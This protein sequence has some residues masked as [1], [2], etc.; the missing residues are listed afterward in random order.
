MGHPISSLILPDKAQ[1]VRAPGEAPS[2]RASSQY[3]AD[4]LRIDK[5][6][7]MTVEAR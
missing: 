4:V 2:V 3:K 6:Q 1:P 7:H 5:G